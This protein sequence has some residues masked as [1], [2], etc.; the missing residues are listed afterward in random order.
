MRLTALLHHVSVNLLRSS[1]YEL[2]KQ[3]APGVGWSDVAAVWIGTGWLKD[4]H[5]RVHRGAYQAQPSKRTYLPKEDGRQR[6]LGIAALEDK[7]VQTVL[8]TVLNSI[9]EEDFPGFSYGFRPQRGA[10]DA[11]DAL[12]VGLT[13][14]GCLGRGT[15]LWSTAGF[16]A[17]ASF[18]LIP[19]C[20]SP[21]CIRGKSRMR[22]SFTYGSVRGGR[23]VTGVPTATEPKGQR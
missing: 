6:L 17:R 7:I 18:T 14:T 9:Y 16:P 5:D 23:R 13:R 1:Y 3:A 4:L 20:A 10:H 21:F 22:Q 8:V 12:R 2:K 19:V 11:W 15:G